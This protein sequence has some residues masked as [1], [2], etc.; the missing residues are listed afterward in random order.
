M[1]TEVTPSRTKLSQD[2]LTVPYNL[3]ADTSNARPDTSG[4][5]PEAYFRWPYCIQKNQFVKLFKAI[6]TMQKSDVVT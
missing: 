6:S 3:A 1:G 5:T 4:P 2:L